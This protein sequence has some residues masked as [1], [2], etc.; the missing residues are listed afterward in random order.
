MAKGS[1]STLERM[2]A[3]EHGMHGMH[4]MMKQVLEAVGGGETTIFDNLRQR[5]VDNKGAPWA[6]TPTPVPTPNE[7]TVTAVATSDST[8]NLLAVLLP[9]LKQQAPPPPPPSP[10]GG[11]VELVVPAIIK[12]LLDRPDPIEQFAKMQELLSPGMADQ[13]MTLAMPE[14]MKGLV[15]KLTGEGGDKKGTD[16][17]DLADA[18]KAAL[19]GLDPADLLKLAKE[20]AKADGGDGTP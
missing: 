8:T 7:R 11:L 4:G 20:Q 12:Y 14:L 19:G 15:G 17:K 10:W 13:A 18:F 16:K 9:F 1:S 3:L 6:P 2:S 5:I